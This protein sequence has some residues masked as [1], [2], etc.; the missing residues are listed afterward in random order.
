M[1]FLIVVLIFCTPAIVMAQVRQAG[2][3]GSVMGV[4]K[5]SSS[6]YELQAV[7]ITILKK[8][9]STLL[10][11]QLTNGQ[12]EF[13]IQSL[14]VAT[15]IIINFSFSGYAPFSKTITLDSSRQ[16]YDFKTVSLSRHYGTLDAVVVEA[17]VPIRMNGDTLEINPAAFKLDSN[18]VVEDMLRR[19]PGVTMWGDGS[20]TVNGKPVN[21]VYVDGKPFFGG[22]PAI[23]TQNLPKNAIEKI[24]VYQEID[25]TVDNVDQNPEDSLL[26]MNIKL[27]ED[28]KIGLFGKAGVGLG[29]DKRYEGDLTLQ[30][31][32]K[33][34]RIGL[35]G[36]GNNINKSGDMR[37]IAQQS[38][39]RNFNPTNRYV[40]N[41]GG[42]GVNKILMGGIN[43]Q[44]DFSDLNNN[45]LN[46][47]ISGTYT[48]RQNANDV[49]T[50][51]VSQQSA[52][53]TVFN[54][55]SNRISR[56]EG[57][58]HSL[59]T[60]YNKKD[61]SQDFS[62][63][64]S[65]NAG[66][67]DASSKSSQTSSREGFGLVS[68]NEQTSSSHGANQSFNFSTSYRNKDDDERNLRSFNINYG[69][70]YSNNTSERQTTTNFISIADPSKS[71]YIDRLYNTS[72]SNFG[73]NIGFGYNAL[74]R[75]LFG[76]HNFWDIN[77][78]FN[79]NL[80]YSH[81]TDD[82]LVNDYDT[83]T[84]NYSQN[85]YL[86]NNEGLS[87]FED[88]PS[89]RF[90][91]NFRK[92]LSDRYSRYINVAAAINGQLLSEQ[93]RSDISNRNLDR[94]FSFF[95]PGAQISYSY[96]RNRRYEITM[97][98][99]Q[100]NSAGIPGVDQLYPIRDSTNQYSFSLGNPNLKPFY[101][102]NIDYS[103]EYKKQS[104]QDKSELNIRTSFKAGQT[105]FGITDS[106]F[107]HPNGSRDIYLINIEKG[108]KTLSAGASI[109]SSFKLKN[110]MLQISYSGNYANN[111]T[112]N[113]IDGIY[114]VATN[115]NISNSLTVFYSLGD[116]LTVQIN[117]GIN[118]N[119]SLQT[120]KN[121]KSFK[122]TTYNTD[123]GVNIKYPKNFVISNT[124][125]YVNNKTANQSAALWNAFVTYR[126]L[127]SQSAE[128]KFSAMDI[129]R[130]NKNISV[131]ANANNL[132]TTVTNGLQ[133]FY[134]LTFSF[135]PRQFGK[136]AQRG[137]GERSREFEQRP[138]NFDQM[139]GDFRGMPG[140][141]GGR[142]RNF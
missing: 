15:P 81:N 98:L 71:N 2:N 112:P 17:V 66:L 36:M 40:A 96:K 72:S 107:Y 48:L 65:F 39:F 99:S 105:R 45:R 42:S 4:V 38:T 46:N 110:D 58:N 119:N 22:D 137:R 111:K 97:D 101:N 37:S 91:R 9:D 70:N 34:T 113:Y 132:S 51:T 123:A 68:S 130:Q 133:Q 3:R 32:N 120:G 90:S 114:S 122:N 126:F 77:I 43:Y 134:M 138:R 86:T 84:H 85:S 117:Q 104:N 88:R 25:Y 52:S 108:R 87:R 78:V 93:N 12:G 1:R 49:N 142:G 100:N 95:L 103:F 116:L 83:L 29:T 131:T 23:A 35:L 64:A 76:N 115:D 18:A 21:K 53:G 60:G 20:I 14:P 26:T 136:P 127:K 54:N 61:R 28:K 89:L 67:T 135:Y 19:V 6:N 125:S 79:N 5:D 141:G 106:S 129:L 140:R 44:H 80:S 102:N 73:T 92:N 11:Y 16:Q 30:A 69:L 139:P 10:D 74:K 121:L 41:F 109:S 118:F 24:Q 8:A 59:S 62:I 75:L 50:E 124:F 56:N 55:E 47:Q 94:K 82:N 57:L 27:K 31:Y 33:R 7:T 13:N 128:L 63:N